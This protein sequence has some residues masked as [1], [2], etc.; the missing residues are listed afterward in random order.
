MSE[1][2]NVIFFM[3]TLNTLLLFFVLCSASNQFTE[4][5]KQTKKYYPQI[6][7]KPKKIGKLFKPKVS[8]AAIFEQQLRMLDGSSKYEI[9]Q[10]KKKKAEI[11]KRIAQSR[12][13]YNA[14]VLERQQQMLKEYQTGK[15]KIQ[16]QDEEINNLK[17][18]EMKRQFALWKKELNQRKEHFKKKFTSAISQIEKEKEERARVISKIHNDKAML[19]ELLRTNEFNFY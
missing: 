17:L 10:L 11:R 9:S 8:T 19:S 2:D 12:Q 3:M 6:H 14:W 4:W 18:R 7:Y 13:K 16:R 15:S 1:T 5:E